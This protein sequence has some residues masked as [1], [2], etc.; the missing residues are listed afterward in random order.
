MIPES[1]VD[2]VPPFGTV[3]A[4][5]RVRAPVEENEE[6]AVAPKAAVFAERLVVDALARV[7]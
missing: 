5:A 1:V 3:R 7:V 2:P 4:E 6:V